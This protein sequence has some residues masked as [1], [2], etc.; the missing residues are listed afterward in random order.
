MTQYREDIEARH[1]VQVNDYHRLQ[2][3]PNSKLQDYST[4]LSSTLDTYSLAYLHSYSLTT[5][6]IFS[7][8]SI[9]T[10]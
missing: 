1:Y 10:S 6:T 5:P 7:S 3:T 2:T 4:G 8:T 9:P